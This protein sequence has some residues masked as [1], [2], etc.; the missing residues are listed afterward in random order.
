MENKKLDRLIA[1]HVMGCRP[2]QQI[3]GQYTFIIWQKAGAREP[4]LEH[5]DWQEAKKWYGPIDLEDI[6]D[7]KHVVIDVPRYSTDI[8]AAWEIVEKLRRDGWFLSGLTA[9]ENTGGYGCRFIREMPPVSPSDFYALWAEGGT[10]PL[11]ICLAALAA[12]GVEIKE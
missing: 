2:W 3:R 9:V 6:D 1:Y 5:R 10:A 11:A 12:V 7:H 4:W 8:A